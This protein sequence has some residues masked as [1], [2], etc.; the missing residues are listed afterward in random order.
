MI[1]QALEKSVSCSPCSF[2]ALTLPSALQPGC[3]SP[4]F[5]APESLGLYSRCLGL[6][7]VGRVGIAEILSKWLKFQKV[8][9][10]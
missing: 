6:G 9:M 7:G 10:L 3:V 4:P 8:N 5:P 1:F 2:I